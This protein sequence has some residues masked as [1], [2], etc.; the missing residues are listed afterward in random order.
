MRIE[1]LELTEQ[2]GLWIAP[3][4]TS[5][6]IATPSFTVVTSGTQGSVERVRLGD[7]SP[8]T[9]LAKARAIGRSHG[10]EAMTWWIG[11]LTT[12]ARLGTQLRELGLVPDAEMP[13]LTSLTI[14]HRPHGT[15]T[16]EVRRVTT[17][18][19]YLRALAIDWAVWD[20]PAALRAERRANAQT[21]WKLL[22]ADG[23]T[24]HHLAL[25][26]S[27]PVGFGRVVF[28]PGA[29]ILMG[30]ATLPEARG[31]GVYT[32]LVHARFDEAVERG[33]PRLAVSAGALSAPILER[34]GFEPIGLVER[35][36]DRL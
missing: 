13:T 9:A 16:A 3:D 35:L 22:Q 23:R 11:E 1:L 4:P 30:G 12:P 36:T 28:A 8:A 26:D 10:L 25:M 7:A 2:P 6:T 33:T 29:G 14:G 18:E 20:V 19:D 31:R 24:G 17:F 21:H 5:T 32:A 34:L 15:P 27:R